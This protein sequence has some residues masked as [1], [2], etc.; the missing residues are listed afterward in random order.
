MVNKIDWDSDQTCVLL[1]AVDSN[2]D[3]P[4]ASGA[5]SSSPGGPTQLPPPTE[6]HVP[7]REMG[8]T[9]AHITSAITELRLSGSEPTAQRINQCATWMIDH[10]LR[11]ERSQGGG[12]G[13]SDQPRPPV[14][15]QV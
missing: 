9:D 10:P 5:S 13:L 6:M 2:E 12:N 14:R 8:F 3:G 7:L 15:P 4:S 11:A 1:Q